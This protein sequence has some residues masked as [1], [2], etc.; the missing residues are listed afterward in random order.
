[1]IPLLFSCEHATCAV[2]EAWRDLFR[3]HEETVESPEGWEP[4]ALNLAQGFA[5][6]LRIPL[7]HGDV[8]RLLIDLDAAGEERWSRFSA[9]LTDAQRT[10]LIERHET[11]HHDVLC[12][13]ATELLRHVPAV[14]H[15]MVHTTPDDSG[16]VVLETSSP[17]TPAARWADTWAH[18]LRQNPEPLR[19]ETRTATLPAP[20]ASLRLFFGP[21]AYSALALRV[22]QSFFL[23]GRPWRWEKLKK[24]LA[25][26]LAATAKELTVSQESPS[27]PQY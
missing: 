11:K 20:T 2:P 23:E 15:L 9:T 3:G 8:T 1:M 21:A 27:S 13:R 7:A 16:A 26:T 24:H 25:D 19:V 17:D 18:L 6:K 12:A 5:I 22:S 14:V 10:K 4:G